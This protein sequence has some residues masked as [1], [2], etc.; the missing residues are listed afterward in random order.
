MLSLRNVRK[1][2]N[3]NAC[4]DHGLT[5]AHLKENRPSGVQ[6]GNIFKV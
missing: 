5:L 1:K 3:R 2:E 6:K 4:L